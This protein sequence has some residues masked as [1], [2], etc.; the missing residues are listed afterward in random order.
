M[1]GC[2]SLG[3]LGQKQ[4]GLVFSGIGACGHIVSILKESFGSQRSLE[5]ELNEA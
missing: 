5:F 3:D 4:L 2:T 1:V